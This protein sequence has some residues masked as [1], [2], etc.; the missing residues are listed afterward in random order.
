MKQDFV[1]S[2]WQGMDWKGQLK[3][4][5]VPTLFFSTTSL[6]IEY[7]LKQLNA[8]LHSSKEPEPATKDIGI[9]TKCGYI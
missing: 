1:S 4:N 6:I 8:E 9:N 7:L 2:Y 3:P 5:A